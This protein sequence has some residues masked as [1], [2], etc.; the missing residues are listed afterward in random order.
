MD[1]EGVQTFIREQVGMDSL[2]LEGSLRQYSASIGA[3]S[4]AVDYINTMISKVESYLKTQQPDTRIAVQ[5]AKVSDKDNL[6]ASPQ[7]KMQY[8]LRE[9]DE[10]APPDSK[11]EAVSEE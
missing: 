4:L 2:D 1:P 8:T 3:D 5:K 9:D 6:D 11:P 7:F 10:E